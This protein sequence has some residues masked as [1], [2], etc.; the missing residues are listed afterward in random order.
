LLNLILVINRSVQPAPEMPR[1]HGG[2]CAVVDRLERMF[3][4]AV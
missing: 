4:A 2:N 3:F 1:A